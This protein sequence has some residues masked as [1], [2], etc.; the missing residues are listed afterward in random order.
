MIILALTLDDIGEDQAM[1]CLQ[2]MQRLHRFTF[3]IDIEN[4]SVVERQKAIAVMF[5]QIFD[6]EQ[7]AKLHERPGESP[8]GRLLDEL[9]D[10]LEGEEEDDDDGKTSAGP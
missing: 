2:Y 6:E 10:D 7:V 4:M 9:L 8:E 1:Y 5:K 3:P